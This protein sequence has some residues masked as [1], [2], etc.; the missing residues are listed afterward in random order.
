MLLLL[1]L[2]LAVAV[3]VVSVVV[4]VVVAGVAVVVSKVVITIRR[5]N[6]KVC[7]CSLFEAQAQCLLC[8]L[9]GYPSGYFHGL[10]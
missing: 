3:V 5:F 2:L 8:V 6:V 10:S 4:V 1:L 9:L 7:T